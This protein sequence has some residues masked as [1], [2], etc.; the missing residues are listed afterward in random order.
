ME[1]R[2]F[3]LVYFVSR[4]LQR[5]K[6]RD[7]PV[8]WGFSQKTAEQ[9]NE[10]TI[11]TPATSFFASS[12]SVVVSLSAPASASTIH[13]KHDRHD[14]N[15]QMAATRQ[16]LRLLSN[17]QQRQLRGCGSSLRVLVMVLVNPRHK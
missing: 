8:V 14:K 13:L 2:I 7:Y 11:I 3:M 10:K 5:K 15:V 6:V 9:G 1:V 4:V 16:R 12:I 17:C